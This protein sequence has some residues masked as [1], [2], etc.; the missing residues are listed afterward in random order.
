MKRLHAD[1]YHQADP[2]AVMRVQAEL[3]RQLDAQARRARVL[4]VGAFSIAG[5]A[6]GA[7]IGVSAII[8]GAV[9]AGIGLAWSTRT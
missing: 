4:K 3:D 1:E 7:F 6:G 8:T 2:E 9:A 5:V